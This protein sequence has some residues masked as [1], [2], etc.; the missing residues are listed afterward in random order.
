[1][2][3]KEADSYTVR[4]W[5]AGNYARAEE[6]CREFCEQG[7]CVSICPMNYIY[8]GGEESGV[9]VTLI[10]YARFPKPQEDI[11]ILAENLAERLRIGLHQQSFT[12]EDPDRTRFFSVRPEDTG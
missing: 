11:D 12:I 6:I 9:C 5:I 1:M 10:N 7:M 4:I 2:L 3:V 8:T